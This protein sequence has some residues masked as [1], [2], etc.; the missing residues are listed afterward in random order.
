MV[1]EFNSPPDGDSSVARLI[2][3]AY[4]MGWRRFAVYHCKGDRFIG[5]GLG[6]DSRGVRIEIYGSSGDYL[7][8]GLDGAEMVVHDDAQDQVGQI[9]NSGRIVVHGMVGQTFLYGAKGG[10]AF[11]LGN[12]A[13]R[14]LINAVGN[15]RA[16]INGTCLDYCAESFMAGAETGG[17]FVV[18][19]GMEF[20]ERG[21]LKRFAE[22]YPGGNFFSLASGGAG[23]IAD[24]DCRLTDDQLNEASFVEF[25]DQDWQVIEP[26]LR[27]NSEYSGLPI[28]ALLESREPRELYR[29]V[30]AAKR[31][32]VA[33]AEEVGE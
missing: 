14:P 5:C 19:N 12:A 17:G 16:I 21:N 23:H 15:M 20:A 33:K 4:R 13:G 7:G 11:V 28:E 8:S 27:E 31:G 32:A 9:F 24:P 26:Y 25:R 22:P 30:S 10:A 1:Q 29:K 18:I 2:V 6:A 3:Q